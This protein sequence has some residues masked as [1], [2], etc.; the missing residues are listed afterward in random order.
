M[1]VCINGPGHMTKMA[2]MAAI[3]DQDG[4]HTYIVETLKILLQN[5]KFYDLETW[6][7]ASGTQAK[8]MTLG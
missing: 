8:M 4:R 5:H 7:A 6:R 3:H 2:K 1:K